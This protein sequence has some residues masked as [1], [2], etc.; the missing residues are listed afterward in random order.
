VAELRTETRCE[1]CGRIVRKNVKGRWAHTHSF[2]VACGTGYQTT[3][4]P[5]VVAE[6]A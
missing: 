4:A 2:M 1:H 3:A 5:K 6:R